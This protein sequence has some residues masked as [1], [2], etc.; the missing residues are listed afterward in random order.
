MNEFIFDLLELS[1]STQFI[2]TSLAF[3]CNKT[4]FTC[5]SISWVF[6]IQW[7][8][9]KPHCL[10]SIS[11]IYDLFTDMSLEFELY[12]SYL[13][14]PMYFELFRDNK[15][16]INHFAWT[17]FQSSMVHLLIS[18]LNL[19]CINSYLSFQAYLQVYWGNKLYVNDIAW[20]VF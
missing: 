12:K 15:L 19:I 8:F 18:C 7:I 14:L 11:V 10:N 1:F 5:A 4:L 17:A 13:I 9:Y 3:Y 6:L 16:Y 2:L 20:T